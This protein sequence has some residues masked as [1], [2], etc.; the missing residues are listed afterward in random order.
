MTNSN[1]Q[2]NNANPGHYMVYKSKIKICALG[3]LALGSVL[4]PEISTAAAAATFKWDDMVTAATSPP[5]QAIKTHWGKGIL[6][7][8]ISTAILG[9]GDGRERATRALWGSAGGAA[10]ILGLIAALG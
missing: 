5:I 3:A 6:L 7:S 1:K 2:L 4:I 9:G 8:G 10:I